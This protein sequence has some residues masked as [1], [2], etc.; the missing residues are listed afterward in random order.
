MGGG[1]GQ[2]RGGGNGRHGTPQHVSPPF[3]DVLSHPNSPYSHVDL[4]TGWEL[5]W[6]EYV[7]PSVRDFVK[8]YSKL[9]NGITIT[10][11]DITAVALKLKV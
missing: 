5:L 1:S 7:P 6:D 3:D 11:T 10:M 2:G 9:C 8:R 4:V